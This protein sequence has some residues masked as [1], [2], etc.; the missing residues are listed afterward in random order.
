[1]LGPA[2][3]CAVEP[4]KRDSGSKE[5]PEVVE[6]VQVATRE[7]T[8][9][10][11]DYVGVGHL[12]IG[13]LKSS[14][15]LG[16]YCRSQQASPTAL[17]ATLRSR[18]AT[19]TATVAPTVSPRMTA[20]LSRASEICK[21]ALVTDVD[22]V[23][24]MSEN[25][26]GAPA[27]VLAR[28]GL[29]TPD[30]VRAHL[31]LVKTAHKSPR[32]GGSILEE[33]GHDLC[34][35]SKSGKLRPSL[36]RRPLVKRLLVTLARE[37]KPNALLVGEAGVGK[38]AIVEALAARIA[39]GEVPP[40][41]ASLKIIAIEPSSLVAGAGIVGTLEARLRAVVEEAATPDVVLFFDE[42]HS[43]LGLGTSSM[44]AADVLKPALARGEIRVIGATTPAEYQRFIEK[45]PATARRFELVEVLEPSV[46]ETLAIL[47]ATR[48]R[49]EAHHG[50]RIDPGAISAAVRLTVRYLP[51]RRLPDKAVDVLDEACARARFRSVPATGPIVVDQAV[52]GEAVAAR[53]GVAIESIDDDARESLLE[54]E[55]RVK[56]RVIGQDAAVRAITSAIRASRVGLKPV[57]RP[58]GAFFLAGPSGVG[59]TLLAESIAHEAFGDEAFL[60]IDLSEFSHAHETARLVGAPPGYVGYDR[61][62]MLTGFLKQHPHAV[63][64]FDEADKAHAA[65][66]DLLLQLL[67]RGG[68]TNGRGDTIDATNSLFLFASNHLAKNRAAVGF[69]AASAKPDADEARARLAGILRPEFVGRLDGVLH[70]TA[71]DAAAFRRVAG[72]LV[73]GAKARVLERNVELEVDDAVLDHLAARGDAQLGARPIRTSVENDI[74][75]PV[76]R[77]LLERGVSARARTRVVVREGEL[78]VEW[79]ELEA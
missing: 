76:S 16:D 23:V 19:G 29:S 73:E 25:V 3:L 60:R 32:R 7:A 27:E 39:Q 43:L 42:I 28:L 15:I 10:G 8:A 53:A 63:V 59:K 51:Q 49:L 17:R 38:T 14:E 41:F 26:S 40:E 50:V 48:A 58:V 55:E 74:V 30:E 9:A 33:L 72:L 77:A 71:L 75:A 18:L 24:A 36:G 45:D 67:D 65:V 12:L 64:L 61:P 4:A 79:K 78:R 20:V 66:L 31:G 62:G 5:S 57:G 35:L 21:N 68:I 13:L 11:H 69:G 54:L 6:A 70:L 56:R 22:V 46:E 34:A 1:M 47:E 52:V 44:S 2:T 37:N